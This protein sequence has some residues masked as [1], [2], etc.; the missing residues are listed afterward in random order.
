[1][2]TVK[3]KKEKIVKAEKAEVTTGQTIRQYLCQ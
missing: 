1:M 2:S 3:D